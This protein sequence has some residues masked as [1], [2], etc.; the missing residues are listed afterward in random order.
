MS[1][2]PLHIYPSDFEAKIGFDRLRQL[3]EDKCISQ[4]GRDLVRKMEFSSSFQE[5]RSRLLATAEMK[6]AIH[7]ASPIPTLHY[8]DLAPA[9]ARIRA[10]ASYMPESDM[11][12]L[13]TSLETLDAMR[14]LFVLPASEP[15]APPHF[16]L[17]ADLA[18][19]ISDSAQIR[20]SLK[21]ILDKNGQIRDDAS[22]RL[23][24]ISRLLAAAIASVSSVMRRVA[25]FARA[26]GIV[27]KDASPA[28]RDGRLVLP[29][30]AADKR[31]I[32]GIIHDESAT[33]KT[34]YIEPREVVEANNRIHTLQAE[35]NREIIVILTQV[36][37]EIRPYIDTLLADFR[38][39]AEFDF[40]RAKALLA[41]DLGASMPNLHPA[42]GIEWYNAFHPILLITLR[43][44]GKSIVPLTIRLDAKKRIMIISGP[45]AGG[46]SVAL[47]TIGI[48]QYMMQC[49]LL[50][51]LDDNSHAGIFRNIFIDIGDQQSIEND[52][53]TYSSHLR[54]MKQFI[55]RT[56]DPRS[57]AL[58]L[59]DEMGSGTEP[60]IGGA[61]AQAILARLD[62]N[63]VFAVITTHYQN[64]K[65]FAKEQ[66]S[67]LNAAM[68]Y[69]RN[70]LQPLF[71]LATGQPGSSFALEIARKTGLPD[72][73]IQ[74]ARDIVGSDYVDMDKYLLDLDRDKKYWTQ[75]CLSIKE[76]EK[77]LDELLSKYGT[78][79]ETLRSQRAEILA[80]ARRQA[81]EIIESSNA[82]IE[83]TIR[84]IKT[85]EAEKQRTRE[86][87]DELRRYASQVADASDSQLPAAI[88][89]PRPPKH[90]R[91]D[92]KMPASTSQA[93]TVLK[94]GDTV[95]IDGSASVGT[96]IELSGKKATV[97]FG[98][99]RTIAA[100]DRLT[101]ARPAP[102][103]A[104]NA[105]LKITQSTSEDIR[106][107]QLAFRPEIDVRGMRAD[108]ALQAVT[109]FL[110][111][112]T[113]FS[114]ERV[115]ILHGTGTGA[116][117]TAIRNLLA[118]SPSV[119]T[120][121]DED[122]R[123]GGAGITVAD[124]H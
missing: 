100:L 54:N 113:Q 71:R 107:R 18:S 51:T 105:T 21:R 8:H 39:L 3:L 38:I 108:E 78:A 30:N 50:P 59:I 115:R 79:A 98:G 1:L 103:T 92:A 123:F 10:Q 124:L 34:V 9:L 96:I 19:A 56:S 22:P 24:E 73:V 117:R 32:A 25:D 36:T 45:N 109:Y 61:L 90:A 49:G 120:Y 85:A 2:R 55:A 86:L 35:R 93:P 77:H 37:A 43:L 60:Q 95:K 41:I 114:A 68:L 53:S 101:P 82:K 52:L 64:L 66:P 27:D 102:V 15:D 5:V 91:T 72:D 106:K 87:R 119:H 47:K 112:A 57:A 26:Q 65:T 118:A 74:S 89:P 7:A 83:K 111:D 84:D 23:A 33:G 116:L 6:E 46:K 29:V 11:Y 16:P 110:D 88:R 69:D 97:A 81:R 14:R 20:T 40:I 4:L 94:K 48:V 31:R 99:V 58:V 75:K 42:P 44:Q 121:H 70:R 13:L 17:L 67:M 12:R 122:V 76:K 28:L 80:D 104:R 63:R 62:A